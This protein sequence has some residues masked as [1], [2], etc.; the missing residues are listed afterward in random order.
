MF[1]ATKRSGSAAD[2]NAE[3]KSSDA[4]GSRRRNRFI[5]VEFKNGM[6]KQRGSCHATVN[7]GYSQECL[8]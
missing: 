6:K 2:E 7:Q 5:V 1:H 8:L 4:K 3:N